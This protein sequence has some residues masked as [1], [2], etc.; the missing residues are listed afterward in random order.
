MQVVFP[1]QDRTRCQ[2]FLNKKQKGQSNKRVQAF[3][4]AFYF[5]N[6]MHSSESKAT[7]EL[8]IYIFLHLKYYE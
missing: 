8:R 4:H 6:K 1:S 5:L 3:L 2:L 7:P